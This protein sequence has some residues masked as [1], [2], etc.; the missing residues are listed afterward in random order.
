LIESS[1]SEQ[2]D[3]SS[4]SITNQKN[5]VFNELVYKSV[6]SGLKEILGESGSSSTIY[7]LKLEKGSF[8]PR[9][10]HERFTEMFHAGATSIEKIIIKELFKS[11]GVQ[12]KER[13]GYDFIG[14]V[15]LAKKIYSSKFR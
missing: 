13:Q 2:E 4:N 1:L 5:R 14:Y 15:E 9:V 3:S 10:F 11:M 8:D 7:Y 12:F 6:L